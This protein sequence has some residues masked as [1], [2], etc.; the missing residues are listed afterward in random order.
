MI[1]VRHYEDRRRQLEF[2]ASR[3]TCDELNPWL[4]RPSESM[5]AESYPPGT[6]AGAHH[7]VAGDER[8][9]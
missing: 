9:H 3:L 6:E 5:W 7:G 8:E 1:G 4:G 2:T